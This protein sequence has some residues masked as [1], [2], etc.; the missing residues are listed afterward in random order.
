MQQLKGHR[1]LEDEEQNQKLLK[2]GLRLDDQVRLRPFY[3]KTKHLQLK[4]TK[5]YIVSE[6]DFSAEE[7]IP[8]MSLPCMQEEHF[9]LELSL[10]HP[11]EISRNENNSRYLLRS[12]NDHPFLLNQQLVFAAYVQHGDC[13]QLGL[14][15]LDFLASQADK[16]HE[17]FNKILENEKIVHSFIPILLEGET[18]TGKS[19]LAKQIHEKSQMVGKFVHINLS[20]FS[21][22]LI[23]SELFGH[24]KGAFTGANFEKKGAFQCADRGTLFIDEVDSL[25]WD[26][27]TKLLLF[28]DSNTIRPVGGNNEKEIRAR[29]IFASGR[30]L[31]HLVEAGKMRKDFYFRLMSGALVQLKPLREDPERISK[32]IQDFS[33]QK[34]VMLSYKLVEFYKSLPWPGNIRELK[35]HL[36]KKL[37]LAQHSRLDFDQEDESLLTQ[38][39]EIDALAVPRRSK[40][41]H[42]VRYEHCFTTFVQ[43]NQNFKLTSEVL[44]I[45]VKTLKR[46]LKDGLIGE[47]LILGPE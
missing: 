18:G 23:E 9:K 6:N 45:N 12:L 37:I 21:A 41:L 29:L 39:F 7:S 40:S 3:G 16:A 24:E 27:Q 17:N 35:G 4:R 20:A 25:S 43:L 5:Y 34:N 31:K 15:K 44:K 47:S 28:L 8:Q 14:N 30:P 13:L 2:E 33:L 11:R 42:E 38:S 26:L 22:N 19:Y 32:I 10:Y 36:E 1:I 46:I